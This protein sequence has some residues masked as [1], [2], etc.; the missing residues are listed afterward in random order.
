[1]GKLPVVSGRELVKA[2][3]KFGWNTARQSSS[4]IALVKSDSIY[5]ISVPITKK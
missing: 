5:T 2:L 1:M 3:A 4:H